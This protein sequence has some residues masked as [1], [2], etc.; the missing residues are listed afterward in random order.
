MSQAAKL[1][2]VAYLAAVALMVAYDEAVATWTAAGAPAPQPREIQGSPTDHRG[3]GGELSA[4]FMFLWPR[5]RGSPS[6]R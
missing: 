6:T 2:T 4:L 3:R 1:F 5:F